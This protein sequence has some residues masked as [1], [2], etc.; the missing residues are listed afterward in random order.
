MLE[1]CLPNALITSAQAEFYVGKEKT[2][3][4]IN[5]NSADLQPH[6]ERREIGILCSVSTG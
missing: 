4:R 6:K 5:I 2:E 1:N 3:G